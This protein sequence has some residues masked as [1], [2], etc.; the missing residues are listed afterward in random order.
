MWPKDQL[1]ECIQGF[2]VLKFAFFASLDQLVIDRN[3]KTMHLAVMRISGYDE[4]EALLRLF[5]VP[6][7]RADLTGKLK[8]EIA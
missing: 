5:S 2:W 4:K 7:L 6:V 8:D 1:M 3:V